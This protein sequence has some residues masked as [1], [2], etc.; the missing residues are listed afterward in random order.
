MKK[1]YELS[2]VYGGYI[3]C[4]NERSE[5]EAEWRDISDYLLPGRGVYQQYSKPR[6]RKLTSPKVVNSV[7]EDALYVLTSGMHGGLTSPSRPWFKLSW[8]DQSLDQVEFLKGW[9]QECEKLLHR[10][11]HNSNF[12]SVINSF[13]V[14]YAGFGTGSIYVGEDT[15]DTGVP[16]RF[17]LLTAGEYAFA[18]G[19]DGRPAVYY[20]TIFMT[21]RQ[22]VERFPDTVSAKMKKMVEEN[23]SGADKTYVTVLEYVVREK[24][25]DKAYTRV[26]FELGSDSKERQDPDREPLEMSGYHEFPYP[27]ARWN[28]I[29]S[30]VY[31]IGPGSRALPDIKRL[32]EMEK[33]F[34]MATHKAINPPLN[35][36]GRMR[37][38]LNTLPGGE[39]YYA[40]PGEVVTEMY[41]VRF[42][43]N[44]VSAAV[45]R[46]EQRIQ[47][48]FFND[49]FLTAARDPNASPLKATQV[50]VQEQ[51][52][53]LRLGPVIERL[54]HEFLQPV[55]ERCF[56]IMLRKEMMPPMPEEY[57]DLVGEYQ[58]ALV[59]PLATAQRAV[60]LQGINS[61]MAF[62]GQAAQFNQEIL[63]N[64][65]VDKAAREYADITGVDLGIL[66]PQEEVEALRSQRAKAMA[67]QQAKA[68]QMAEAEVGAQVN[69][70]QAQ[71]QKAQAEAGVT[72]IEGQTKAQN[73][74]I[75]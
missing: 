3:D 34:L 30:D 44:G 74:G 12:Y 4:Q 63:D 47:R 38:K 37:G 53:M 20:R 11:L 61:F 1:K 16:F 36:P 22:I 54:Q 70:Q 43:Y 50:N 19:A 57:A 73:A 51:E 5:F 8:M 23:D 29:G 21:P 66:R 72:L 52:K 14:E 32:Q 59:S 25:Q 67:A 42:D 75:M 9:L 71:A 24:F 33:A 68:E 7:A 58:I 40:N 56:N 62:L 28:T 49:I 15:G 10:G 27:L 6:K 48:N 31:G 39:N 45:E 55:I 60:A 17:E 65:D 69:A 18:V 2:K 46:V 64:I 35:V 13:Y 26:F 41:Q